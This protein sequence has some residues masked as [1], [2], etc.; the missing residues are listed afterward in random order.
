MMNLNLQLSKNG[1]LDT[2]VNQS[3]WLINAQ[4]RLAWR[5]FHNDNWVESIAILHKTSSDSP[6]E[7]ILGGHFEEVA[8]VQLTLRRLDAQTWEICGQLQNISP[9]PLELARLHYLHG[10]L[11]TTTGLLAPMPHAE[12]CR[13]FRRGDTLPPVK[14]QMESL[15]RSMSVIWPRL[16]DP[17]HMQPD[18]ALALDTGILTPAWDAPGLHLG[19]TGPVSAFGEIG[20]HTSSPQAICF[21]GLLLDGIRL[22]PGQTRR[23]D[24]LQLRAGDWQKSLRRWA[25]TCAVSLGVKPVRLPLTGYCSW[26]QHY[27]GV[28]AE[29]IER[30]IREFATWPT[31]P[32]GRTIQIDDGFQIMPGDWRP[33]SRFAESWDQLPFQITKTGA[34]PGLWIA[35]HAIF[36]RHPI[37]SQHPEWLQ[38]LPDGTPAVSFSNW[39]WCARPDAKW[40]DMSEPTYFLDPDHPEARQFMFDIVTNAVHAGWKYL[41]IDF[42]YALST[43]RKSWDPGKTRMETLRE[44]YRLFREAAGPDTLICACIGEMGRYA[45]G[46]ADTARLGGD[47]G[48]D[49]KSI[50]RNLPDTLIRMSTNGIWWNGDPDVFHMRHENLSITNEEAWCLTGTI[51]MIG[52]VFLTSD[53]PSQWSAKAQEQVRIF[54]NSNGPKMPTDFYVAYSSDGLPQ[55]IRFSY[56]SDSAIPHRIVV[57]NWSDKQ[58][59]LRLPLAALR[60]PQATGIKIKPD[61]TPLSNA[62]IES[63][64]LICDNLSPHSLCIIDLI[65]A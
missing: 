7:M 40:D 42:S 61:L 19:F 23:L 11:V 17:I 48:G 57:Y 55:A 12:S 24:N 32:G 29:H 38:R 5:R 59:T 52:G 37:C 28:R 27:N 8:K 9:A 49:W 54:W 1:T 26:Y 25:V 43:A 50:H 6:D 20:L 53:F 62:R 21:A 47:I 35:P 22:D 46:S 56:D 18:W 44:M 36:H 3:P 58:A 34:I 30:A 13:L 16:A 39:S 4:P 63:Q 51:G 64:H 10:E 41:K 45:L 31:P 65:K 60:F 2:L 15:W 33:N 14:H